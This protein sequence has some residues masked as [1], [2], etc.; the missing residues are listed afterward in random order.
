ML[1]FRLSL[2][3]RVMSQCVIISFIFSSESDESI[4]LFR[5]SVQ[6]VIVNVL[7]FRLSLVQRVMS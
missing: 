4:D 5:L 6:R 2:V 7:L 3:Q 1:L